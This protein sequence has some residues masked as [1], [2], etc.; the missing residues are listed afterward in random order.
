MN[1]KLIDTQNDIEQQKNGE[2]AV[3]H[4]RIATV[5]A[6]VVCVLLAVFV[7]AVIMG[8]TD[9]DY[10]PVELT[11]TNDAYT[12]TVSVDLIE[13]TGT[14]GALRHADHVAIRVPDSAVSGVYHLTVDDLVLP[15]GIGLANEVDIT[16]TVRAK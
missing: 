10:V 8:T 4:S 11:N 1:R 12:Y 15:E 5:I 13:V 6:A 2:Y 7:W 16:L 9:S 14:V 3:R